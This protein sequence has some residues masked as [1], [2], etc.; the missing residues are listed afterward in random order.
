M[1]EPLHFSSHDVLLKA[2]RILS[3]ISSDSSLPT[4]VKIESARKLV[5]DYSSF[6]VNVKEHAPAE[7]YEAKM[8]KDSIMEL[9]HRRL[10]YASPSEL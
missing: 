9:L 7:E 2:V 10:S 5:D 6:I 1:K 8:L 3:D 4:L